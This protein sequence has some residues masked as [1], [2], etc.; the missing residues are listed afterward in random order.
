MELIPSA[1]RFSSASEKHCSLAWDAY[2]V[3]PFGF[4]INISG[5]KPSQLQELTLEKRTRN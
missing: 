5:R 2:R 4:N 1:L 3:L